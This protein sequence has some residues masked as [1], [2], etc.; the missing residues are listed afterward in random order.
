MATAKEIKAGAAFIE[1][2][3]DKSPF[4]RG[5][6]ALESDF[7]SI[8]KKLVGVGSAIAGTATAALTG[9]TL[10][11]KEF[12]DSA[13]VIQ[14]ISD[15]TG[16]AASSLA[17]LKFAADQTGTSLESLE[18]A[19]VGQNKF[20]LQV[21][22]GGKEAGETLAQLGISGE[23]L[24]RANQEQRFLLLADGVSRVADEGLR[25]A[26]AM[27]V[28]GKSGSQ[29]GPLIAGGAAGVKQLT[30]QARQLG[31]VMSDA[32]IAAGERLGDTFDQL[33]KLLAAIRQQVGVALV[34]TFQMGAEA[35]IRFLAAVNAFVASNREMV[36]AAFW[37]A[38]QVGALGAAVI[39][40]GTALAGLGITISGIFAGVSALASAV[41][42]LATPIGAVVGAVV[43][44]IAVFTD[45]GHLTDQLMASLGRDLPR[46]MDAFKSSLDAGEVGLAFDIL[47][48]TAK[49]KFKEVA[50]V[51]VTELVKGVRDGLVASTKLISQFIA[52][53]TAQAIDAAV[54]FGD[55]LIGESQ[56][57]AN[58]DR[59]DALI[60]K[61]NDLRGARER[62]AQAADQ[63]E[64]EPRWLKLQRLRD[65]LNAESRRRIAIDEQRAAE[66]RFQRDQMMQQRQQESVQ[67]SLAQIAEAHRRALEAP[68]DQQLAMMQDIQQMAQQPLDVELPPEDDLAARFDGLFQDVLA[69]PVADTLGQRLQSAVE[70]AADE[71]RTAATFSS[72]EAGR[73]AGFLLTQKRNP[74]ERL[75]SLTT[76]QNGLIRDQLNALKNLEVAD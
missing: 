68:L 11:T 50:V 25:A 38:V 37:T 5:L 53:G 48:E 62:A 52:P 20:L 76:Q 10:A 4:L 24:L 60:G 70:L 15:R 19:L 12:A 18:R 8:G 2:L 6:R 33:F 72:T 47:I 7:K 27:K 64:P 26:L 57:R 74:N 49:V 58:T 61:A 31:L 69:D 30:D 59:L 63:G 40:A 45:W 43:A 39:A 23:Q 42:F 56:Y 32:D 36:V 41:A 29:L 71:V 35:I 73:T 34:G 75:E 1:L 17:A 14:D 65:Q 67:R 13:S 46:V 28:F 51:I 66:M 55:Q 21:S 16:V 3:L 9:F 44:M 22:Q 54:K